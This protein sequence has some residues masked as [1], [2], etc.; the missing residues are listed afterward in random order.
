MTAILGLALLG[1]QTPLPE[2]TTSYATRATGLARALEGLSAKSGV[3]LTA[4]PELAREIVVIEVENRPLGEVMTRLATASLGRWE[5]SGEGFRLLPDLNARAAEE[6]A[7]AAVRIASARKKIADELKPP[8]PPKPPKAKTKGEEEE[9]EEMVMPIGPGDKTIARLLAKLDPSLFGG[10]EEDRMVFATNPTRAQRPMPAGW[11]PIIDAYVKARNDR[12]GAMS[13]TAGG[14][15]DAMMDKMPAFVKEMIARQTRRIDGAAKAILAIGT[16]PFMGGRNAT[17]TIYDGQGKAVGNEQEWLDGGMMEAIMARAGAAVKADAKPTTKPT[18]LPLSDDT[19]A[20][21]KLQTGAVAGPFGGGGSPDSMTAAIPPALRAK[22]LRPDL[23]DPLSFRPTDMVRHYAKAQ[24]RPLVAVLPDS[25]DKIRAMAAEDGTIESVAANIDAGIDVVRVPDAAFV[26]LRPTRGAESRRLRA[27]RPALAR[28]LAAAERDGSVGLND[29]A[30]YAATEPDPMRTVAKNYLALLAP[31]AFTMGANGMPDWELLRF[32]GRLPDGLRRKIEGGV[33]VTVGEVPMDARQALARKLFSGKTPF[34]AANAPKKA[35]RSFWEEMMETGMMGAFG[36]GGDLDSEPTQVMPDGLVNAATI[37]GAVHEDP[38]FAMRRKDGTV[39]GLMG[40]PEMGMLRFM[41]E[42]KNF[43]AMMAGM[44][45]PLGDL[46]R[47]VRR[48][49]DL[50]VQVSPTRVATGKL[51][52]E[53]MPKGAPTVN[54]TRLPA[55][56]EA[57][58]A[59]EAADIK[60]SPMGAMGAFMGAGQNTIKP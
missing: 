17:L 53:R 39:L 9:D 35:D 23:T 57:R 11:Q 56:L 29:V 25:M 4:S 50:T 16:T 60:K 20:F 31:G 10:A 54:W 6:R 3:A 2:V 26:V 47:G 13:S 5:P 55:D 59:K 52:D 32:W 40:L 24:K 7:E 21:E 12:A 36:G 22:L 27:D 1:L 46:G 42:D 38:L 8:A 19:K 28:L 18:P 41:S 37:R 34:A 49:I 44:M 58:V 30:A 51:N 45:P 15:E 33:P 48:I 43:G 14:E